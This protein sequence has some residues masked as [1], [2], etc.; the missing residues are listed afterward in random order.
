[1]AQRK[2]PSERPV[3]AV[4]LTTPAATT[5]TMIDGGLLDRVDEA[6]RLASAALD[7]RRRAEMGQFLTPAPVAQFMASLF[8]A[9]HKTIRLLDAGAGVGSLSAAFVAE[10]C[11][12]KR[13]PSKLLVTTYELDPVLLDGLRTTLHE[14]HRACDDAGIEFHADVRAQDFIE[15]ATDALAG[16]LFA[17]ARPEHYECAI[18]NPPYRKIHSASKER[19]ALRR[20]GVETSNLYTA[21]LAISLKLLAADGEMVAITPRSFCNG[22]YFL[23]F[24]RLL[25]ETAALRRVHVFERRDRAFAE[26]DVLQENVIFQVVRGA[27]RGPV[28]VSSSHGPGLPLS[29]SRRVDHARLCSPTDPERVIHIAPD[30]K[31]EQVADRIAALPC[32]LDQLSLGVSTGRV[33]DFRAREFLRREAEAGTAPLIYP[34]H[35]AAGFVAWPKAGGRKANAIVDD[36]RTADLLIPGATYVLVKRFSSKEER[37]RIVAAIYDPARVPAERVGFENHLNYYHA[38]GAGL[39]GRL[40]RGLAAFLN[41]TVV[42]QFFRQFSGHTQVNATDLRSLRY[43]SRGAMEALGARIGERMP[44][45][46]EI[47]R[48]AETGVFGG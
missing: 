17:T 3:S 9:R 28:L 48:F 8:D 44:N 41:T 18:L 21:F 11:G 4:D 27:A 32:T 15:E 40:A 37:R 46:E 45:Q 33:V 23:P 29:T 31:D 5:A 13:H 7:A 43:P 19:A 10:M 24:R 26:D 2:T 34:A 16:G 38:Q 12:R 14:C 42:D 25:L 30:E 22:P 47:D 39:P 36:A 1:M 20:V 6:R 35:F